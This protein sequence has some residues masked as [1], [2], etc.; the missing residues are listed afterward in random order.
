MIGRPTRG[1]INLF[2]P[3][4]TCYLITLNLPPPTIAWFDSI[5]HFFPVFFTR[6]FTGRPKDVGYIHPIIIVT[7][8]SQV[9][10][11]STTSVAK[12]YGQ[13][14]SRTDPSYVRGSTASLDT[15]YLHQ[16]P[17]LQL[18]RHL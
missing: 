1:Y 7:R 12:M 17:G 4:E 3:F 2:S 6:I 10:G 15:H 16:L 14:S 11:I 8:T 13:F 5:H 18:L 9:V